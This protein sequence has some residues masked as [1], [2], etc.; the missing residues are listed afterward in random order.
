MTTIDRTTAEHVAKLARIGVGEAEAR[1]FSAELGGI[2]E[3]VAKLNAL[4]TS[5][6]APTAQV[7][8]LENQWRDDGA[9]RVPPHDPTRLTGAFPKRRGRFLQVEAIFE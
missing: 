3:Y 4:D 7:G 1:R 2:L 5:S 8:D 9:S 6:V